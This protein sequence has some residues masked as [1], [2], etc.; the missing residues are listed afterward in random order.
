MSLIRSN[1]WPFVCVTMCAFRHICVRPRQQSQQAHRLGPLHSVERGQQWRP[2]GTAGVL[3]MTSITALR[4]LTLAAAALIGLTAGAGAQLFEAQPEP[5]TTWGWAPRA[6]TLA[7][8]HMISAANPLAVEA[9]LQ[10]LRAGGSA[11]DAAVATQ[12]VLNLVEPQSSGIGGGAFVL[13]WDA[14]RKQLKSYDGRETAPAAAKPDRFL[15][16]NQP[17]K[18]AD[19]IFGGASVGVP[20]TLR[21]LEAMHRAHG[22][23]AWAQLFGPAIRLAE[24]GFRVSP[25]LHFLLRWY[26]AESF[27]PKP[28][29]YF[30]DQTGSA[31]PAGYLLRNPEFAATLRA[32]AERGASA[33]YDGAIAQAIVEAV[34]TAP[35]HQGDITLADLA[36]YQVKERDPLCFAYRQKRICSMG[37]PSSGGIAVAQALKLVEGFDL[38]QGPGDALNTRAMHLVA[39]AEKL[40]FAD[41]NHYV[42]DPD[43]V[44]VPVGLLDAGYL[45]AR[46]TL[47]SPEAAMGRPSPGT[48]PQLSSV[49]PGTDATTEKEGT[50]HISIIDD[51][52]NVLSMTTTI[53][54]GFGSRLWA[55]GFLLNNEMTDFAFRPHD[56]GGRPLANAVG[57][58]KRPRSSMAPTIV[59]DEQGRPWAVLGSPG[60]SRIILYVVKALVALIDWKMDAQQA[61]SLMN[62]G[63]RGGAFEIEIDHRAALWHALK[64]KPYGHTVSADLLNSGTHVIVLRQDGWLEGGADPRREG[65]ARG[66]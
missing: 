1:P 8:S 49:T 18:L 37:P 57:P 43:F 51:Q 23:L 36:N 5:G 13:H 20:G 21:L 29:R 30:F 45:T 28:R 2:I 33:F 50:S 17:M 58:G 61:A 35:N 15:V 11:A 24:D 38:G 26:G 19:A 56:S 9:G 47:I 7:K 41:R 53:E 16:D 34:G 62:F 4:K 31:R 42:G 14:S 66:D 65:V 12:L 55:A 25:R 44:R 22:R 54:A 3:H 46:R 64:M 6:A 32:I 39:E 27:A 40:A 48:P 52:G 63:S 10:M 60:G 59:F